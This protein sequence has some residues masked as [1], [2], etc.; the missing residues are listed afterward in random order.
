M[1]KSVLKER[2][3][4]CKQ[5]RTDASQRRHNDPNIAA[6][7]SSVMMDYVSNHSIVKHLGLVHKVNELCQLLSR[8]RAPK[9]YD[10]AVTN[11]QYKPVHD[12]PSTCR[13]SR[14]VIMEHDGGIVCELCGVE[15]GRKFC[16]TPWSNNVQTRPTYGPSKMP[17]WMQ[18]SSYTNEERVAY[19][20][21]QDVEQWAYHVDMVCED[22]ISDAIRA[23]IELAEHASARIHAVVAVLLN[24]NMHLP[25][26]DVETIMRNGG[27]LVCASERAKPLPEW[28]CH[29]C[30]TMCF[31]KKDA[32]YHCFGSG[33]RL[34]TVRSRQS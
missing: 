26:N 2:L 29:K 23:S 4:R 18:Y 5:A 19:V 13:H 12:S 24:F 30:A 11:K 34:T 27:T 32:R 14:T 28:P 8:L 10:D 22:D 3:N 17:K 9:K 25:K 6:L 16:D 21:K 7:P 1:S 20:I 33:Q 15:V 31:S